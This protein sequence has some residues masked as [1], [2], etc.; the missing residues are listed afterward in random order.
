MENIREASSSLERI[1]I[2]RI[3]LSLIFHYNRY[4]RTY[5]SEGVCA[6][7]NYTSYFSHFLSYYY[8]C[9]C[10]SFS[11]FLAT[12]AIVLEGIPC[13]RQ[14]QRPR[15]WPRW[16]QNSVKRPPGSWKSP[17]QFCVPVM[18]TATFIWMSIR[19]PKVYLHWCN[20]S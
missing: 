3:P 19:G 14:K 2:F 13:L 15:W 17:G 12:T 8:I 18:S 9:L 16:G 11:L 4:L 20:T 5:L 10:V 7:I 1:T 6:I